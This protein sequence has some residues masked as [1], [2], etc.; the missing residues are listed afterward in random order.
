MSITKFNPRTLTLF[1]FIFATGIIRTIINFDENISILSNFSPLGAM[2]L[3]GGVYFN[4]QWKAFAFPIFSLLVS[5]LILHQTVFKKYGN[6][7]L[8]DGWY[9]VY[10]AILIMV[11]VGWL[12]RKVNIGNIFLAT[13]AVVFIHWTV[14]DLSVWL[15]NPKFPQTFAGYFECLVLA[16]PFEWRFFVGTLVYSAGLFGAFEW[17]KKK[18]PVLATHKV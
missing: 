2:A 4:R 15:N 14:T 5:D 18:N 16:I 6:G 7:L 11:M 8:Y 1:A 9:Y 13:L 12:I 10:A 17:M 3:F